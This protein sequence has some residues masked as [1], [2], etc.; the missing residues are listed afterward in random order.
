MLRFTTKWDNRI[1]QMNLL[2]DSL[3]VFDSLPAPF[4]RIDNLEHTPRGEV[5]IA[6][7]GAGMRILYY[8]QNT[9]PPVTLVQIPEHSDSEITGL[10]FDPGGT[11]LYFSSQ[12]GS[13]GSNWDGLTFEL[14]GDFNLLTRNIKLTSWRLDHAKLAP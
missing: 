6:E 2:D 4:Q 3:V 1:W 11:R 8:P 14:E 12:R 5:M 9:M 13:T 10:A 7:E